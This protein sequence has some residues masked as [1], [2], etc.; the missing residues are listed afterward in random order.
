MSV[1]QSLTL[2]RGSNGH[3]KSIMEDT[4]ARLRL[5][6]WERMS[7]GKGAPGSYGCFLRCCWL[8]TTCISAK[9]LLEI[10][11]K[12]YHHQR[13]ECSLE[14]ARLAGEKHGLS[15]PW[16]IHLNCTMTEREQHSTRKH[17]CMSDTALEKGWKPQRIQKE[18]KILGILNPCLRW[19]KRNDY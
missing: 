13:Q 4:P 3:Y 19:Y 2:R 18:I 8:E 5:W 12:D 9:G 15:V 17:Q 6:T 7:S 11:F 1:S 16:F 14:G 10:C